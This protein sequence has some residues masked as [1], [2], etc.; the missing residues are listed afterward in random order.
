MIGAIEWRERVLRQ[1]G[2]SAGACLL[3][4]ALTGAHFDTETGRGR[5]SL[6][7]LAATLGVP[8]ATVR[9]T[10]EELIGLGFLGDLALE[11]PDRVLAFARAIPAIDPD[12]GRPLETMQ[13]FR[14]RMQAEQG[15][16]LAAA[17][18]A[19][20]G[21]QTRARGFLGMSERGFA[22][23]FRKCHGLTPRAWLAR[24]QARAA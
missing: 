5:A 20:G 8:V 14:A 24:D 23:A 9:R 3:A 6:A 2:V 16:L 13:A 21:N 7:Q 4:E 15:R 1:A 10:I 19:A 11:V 12:T 17:L 18:R 22:Q